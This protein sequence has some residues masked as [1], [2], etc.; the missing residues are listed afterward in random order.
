MKINLTIIAALTLLFISGCGSSSDKQSREDLKE[1]L[2]EELKQEFAEEEKTETKEEQQNSSEQPSAATQQ[3]EVRGKSIKAQFEMMVANTAGTFFVFKDPDGESTWY[4][5]SREAEGLDFALSLDPGD[6][7]NKYNGEWY[8]ITFEERNEE[9]KGTETKRPFI[10]KA[11]PASDIPATSKW[12]SQ[13]LK[14]L[15]FNGVEPNWT[16]VLKEKHAEFTPMGKETKL[17]KYD[18]APS[19]DEST[20]TAYT[21]GNLN[22]VLEITGTIFGSKTAKIIIEEK[23]CSDGMSE[24]TY[25]FSIRLQYNGE[26]VYE[27]CGQP[28]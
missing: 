17:I 20:L 12:K 5:K 3:K 11:R 1:E 15:K 13:S 4:R 22:D 28:K 9:L 23:P 25:P 8:E 26:R 10:L 6:E 16:L 14:N 19:K 24:N 27:G 7:N 18:K 21:K 2:K